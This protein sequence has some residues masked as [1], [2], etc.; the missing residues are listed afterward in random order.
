MLEFINDKL[1]EFI[2][3]ELESIN[4]DKDRITGE[5]CR[6]RTEIYKIYNIE[7]SERINE[8]NDRLAFL[9]KYDDVLIGQYNLLCKRDIAIFGLVMN[10]GESARK[11]S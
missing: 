2:D 3:K 1:K 10:I 11:E 4:S 7:H 5:K 8:Q 9:Q 6:N